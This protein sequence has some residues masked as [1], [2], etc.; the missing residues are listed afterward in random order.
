MLDLDRRLSAIISQAF[1]D[2]NSLTSIFKLITILGNLL[3]RKAIKTDF[4]PRYA[5][6]VAM[7]EREMDDT[8]KIYDEQKSAKL[9]EG[10]IDVHRN[11]PE[12]SGGLKWCQE[13]RDRVS[14]PMD[15][16]KRL[17]DHPIVNSEQMDRVNKKY[18]ELLDLLN[19]F[20]LEIY[21]DWCNHVGKLSNNNLE[22]NLIVRDPKTKS[23]RTNFDPQVL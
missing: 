14:R 7:L 15:A 21:K 16:F 20:G 19:V 10:H 13:L 11:M 17:I 3:E 5:Q 22:K 4:E 23:I 18:K 9:K 1:D 8:K 2:C 12:V 6:I